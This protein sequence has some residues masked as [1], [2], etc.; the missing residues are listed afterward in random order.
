MTECLSP[1]LV[2]IGAM[3]NFTATKPTLRLPGT[4]ILKSCHNKSIIHSFLKNHNT[5]PLS[6]HVAAKAHLWVEKAFQPFVCCILSLNFSSCTPGYLQWGVPQTMLWSL[7]S[8]HIL[9]KKVWNPLK[10]KEVFKRNVVITA[11]FF[12]D[13][14]PNVDN[15]LWTFNTILFSESEYIYLSP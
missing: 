14:K 4:R 1:V 2:Q 3:P 8:W 13:Y 5:Y 9:P 15:F 12:F 6:I 7:L 10:K 11:N